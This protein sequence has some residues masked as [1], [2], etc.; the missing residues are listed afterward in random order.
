MLN[1]A[2]DGG[3]AMMSPA[4]TYPCLTVNLPGGCEATEPDKYYPTGTRNYARVAPADDYQG[5]AVAEFAQKQ[6]VKSVYILNDKEAVRSRRRDDDSA[7]QRSRSGSR[8]P[9]S[10]RGIGRPRATRRC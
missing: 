8:S 2:P 6:G 7:R 4:N 10:R 3:I 1:Q 9:G 5:A